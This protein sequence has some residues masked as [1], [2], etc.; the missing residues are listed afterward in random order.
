MPIELHQSDVMIVET[1]GT[2][3]NRTSGTPDRARNLLMTAARLLMAFM[4]S[5]SYLSTLVCSASSSTAL[6]L[7]PCCAMS[8]RTTRA[9]NNDCSSKCERN[10][11]LSADA[12]LQSI[13]CSAYAFRWHSTLQL[14]NVALRDVDKR[15]HDLKRL[16]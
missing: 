15:H 13:L 14:Q 9:A 2:E 1:K 11:S 3:T 5:A 4:A 6:S 10:S 12:A 8:R 16:N 7:L